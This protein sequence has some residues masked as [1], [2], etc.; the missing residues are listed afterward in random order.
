MI[1]S[2]DAQTESLPWVF[3]SVPH[4]EGTEIAAVQDV[5]RD[6][7]ISSV[8]PALGELEEKLGKQY[9]TNAV[10][11]SSGTAAIHLGLRALGVGEGDE[12]IVQTLTFAG[13]VNPIT[14]LGANPIFLDSE[15]NTMNM[16]PT[17][18]EDF[19]IKRARDNRLPKA[20]M[21][22][23]LFGQSAEYD[24]IRGLAERY[25]IPILEDAAEAVGADFHGQPCGTLGKIGV[26]SLNGNKIITCSGGGIVLTKDSGLS[27][28]I[29]FWS[30]Q[31]RDPDPDGLGN[32]YH[33]EIGFNYR[34]SN[35]LAAIA[36]R[37]FDYVGKRVRQRRTVASR[38][39]DA[40]Q[41]IPGVEL[42]PEGGVGLHTRWLSC[43]RVNESELGCNSSDLIR[44]L[45]K[46]K[47]D[48]RPVW[49]PIHLQNAYR[50]FEAVGGAVAE[51]FHH[52]CI[53]L[54]SSSSLS[55]EDQD[56]VIDEIREA[57]LR[58]RENNLRI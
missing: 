57:G 23:D 36:S 25:G 6:N 7:W 32:Y 9:G 16:D 51:R 5:F 27:E 53:C 37:Q 17:L 34:M 28:K 19:L 45:R 31:A 22:V 41:G 52:E 47:V 12:V 3:L 55:I 20:I 48:C 18:L 2:K 10:A 49:R 44:T 14:Y 38:Y 42:I 1:N 29:R 40:F 39:H 15:S 50:R 13:T 24:A 8:G 46:Q 54:P 33:S 11:V 4:M 35:V 26:L 58:S 21:P 43:C 56:R 30:G